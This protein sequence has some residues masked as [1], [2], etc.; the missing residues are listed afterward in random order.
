MKMV[1]LQAWELWK[2]GTALELKDPTLG[3]SC[4]ENELLRVIQVGLLCVQEDATDRP[5]M[6][7]VIS[8][9]NNETMVLPASTRPA[10]FTG[11]NVLRTEIMPSE[12]EPKDCSRNYLTASTMEAR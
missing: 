11:R 8:M 7:D 10:F 9:L 6:S 4:A 3:D 2:E 5:T 1:L 12:S